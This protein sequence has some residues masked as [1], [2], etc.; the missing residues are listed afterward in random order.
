MSFPTN[1]NTGNTQLPV[2]E[3]APE[4]LERGMVVTRSQT[5]N[6]Y[7][8]FPDLVNP[9]SEVIIPTTHTAQVIGGVENGA[10]V[11][12]NDVPHKALNTV[13]IIP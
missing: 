12:S 5:D 9:Q 6:C 11:S 13:V 2:V 4:L 1:V 7:I 10:Q 8:P 3:F